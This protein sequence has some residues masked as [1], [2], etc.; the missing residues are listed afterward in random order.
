MHC[1]WWRWKTTT[2]YLDCVKNLA[3]KF[4][5]NL[6]YSLSENMASQNTV[7]TRASRWALSQAQINPLHTLK[8]YSFNIHFSIILPR[9]PKSPKLS[10]PFRFSD[11]N[12]VHISRLSNTCYFLRPS[13]SPSFGLPNTYLVKGT[14][15]E[16]P[17]YVIFSSFLLLSLSHFE[18]QMFSRAPCSQTPSVYIILFWWET[19]F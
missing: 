7:F 15:Y 14:N 4:W 17:Q 2:K 8:H 11:I 16:V 9:T 1:A 19:K 12:S 18:I 13:Y 10:L 5:F 3:S 6:F